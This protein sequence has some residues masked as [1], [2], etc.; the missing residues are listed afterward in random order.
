VISEAG[1]DVI[2]DILRIDDDGKTHSI[3]QE[4]DSYGP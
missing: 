2:D 4:M 3:R 1:R